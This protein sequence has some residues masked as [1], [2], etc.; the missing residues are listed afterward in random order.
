[1]MVMCAMLVALTAMACVSLSRR[2]VALVASVA[3][4]QR[5]RER[6]GR[7]FSPEVAAL[8]AGRGEEGAPGEEREITILFSDL[9][10]FTTLSERLSGQQV[11]ALLNEVDEELVEAVFE[12]GGT[13][14]K[15]LGDGLM[16]YFGAPI[17]MPDHAERGGG[18]A[19]AVRHRLHALN[20]P[21]AGRSTP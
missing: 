6:L 16:A 7:Y 19:V 18:G 21:R 9:R 2:S 8:L 17:G 4:E 12:H 11:V 3:R 14:D 1:I 5:Q 10:G 15:Y 13:L 20:N